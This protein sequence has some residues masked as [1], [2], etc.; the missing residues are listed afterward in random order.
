M[1]TR[2][3]T[4]IRSNIKDFTNKEMSKADFLQSLRSDIMEFYPKRV[5]K[6][7][8][9]S[10]TR[11]TSIEQHL[12]IMFVSLEPNTKEGLTS[13]EY[14]LLMNVDKLADTMEISPDILVA[15]ISYQL[16][17][18]GEITKHFTEELSY[19]HFTDINPDL[20]TVAIPYLEQYLKLLIHLREQRPDD[21]GMAM[22]NGVVPAD[23][24]IKTLIDRINFDNLFN[25]RTD[26][27]E[28][29]GAKYHLPKMFFKLLDRVYDNYKRN[30]N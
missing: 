17:N 1:R 12:P 11:E 14:T 13:V 10:D 5:F 2:L 4:R 18:I 8:D 19:K 7:V 6:V 22:M 27:V 20:Q 26:L 30:I 16:D 28:I 15:S 21:Y 23:M 9:T 3:Y 24:E 29:G 25:M